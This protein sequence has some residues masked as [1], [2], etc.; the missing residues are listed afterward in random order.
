M[1]RET[2]TKLRKF[3]GKPEPLGTS[4]A[5]ELVLF[6]N[7]AYLTT[8]ERRRAAF[9]LLKNTIGTTPD[10]ILRAT[11]AQLERVTA[12]GIL[13]TRFAAKLRDC[14][15]IAK[16]HF[17]GNL[18]A[19]LDGTT[20]QA[21]RALRRF[22]G[23]GVP[24]AERILLF[25]GRLANLAPE[26]NGLRVL[27]RLGLIK[28]DTYARMYKAGVEAGK[29]LPARIASLQQAHLLLRQHGHVLC[30][31]AAPACAQCPLRPDCAFA[32]P[33]RKRR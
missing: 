1:L 30:R 12:H 22:P 3:Y 2:A 16:D 32:N 33:P 17:D 24:G 8:P 31:I 18:A 14:A 23:I 25:S 29:Q 21:V 13:K 28:Q 15:R 11:R 10:A 5:F 27:E 6:E 9:D 20:A 26:S 19:A 4:D 7:V